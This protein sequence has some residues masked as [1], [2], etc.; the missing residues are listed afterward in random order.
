M[1]KIKILKDI[2]NKNNNIVFF[3]GAG[4]STESGIPDF[5]GADGIYSYTP[6]TLL[7]HSFFTSEPGLFFEFYKNILIFKD[8]S[9]N[10]AHKV[11]AKMEKDKKLSGIITQ[12]IDSLHQ[13]AGS[14]KVF[15]L[16]GTVMKNH[17]TKCRKFYSLEKMLALDS[18][19]PHCEC[20]GIIK[21]D[22]VLYEESLDMGILENSILL[23]ENADVL[24][25]GGTSLMVNPAASLVNYFSGKYLVIINIDTTSYDSRADLLIQGKIG[26]TLAEAYPL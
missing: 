16:H 20:G 19:V 21:P 18:V 25:I 6:E 9:P 23:I 22:V 11:L 4:V 14:S 24:I 8:A 10:N 15:E 17:C 1:D 26:E 3:G 12:N 7:S 2:L 13:K 5:R